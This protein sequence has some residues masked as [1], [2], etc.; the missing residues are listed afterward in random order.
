MLPAQDLFTFVYFNH[1]VGEVFF[2]LI[3]DSWLLIAACWRMALQTTIRVID[4]IL[5]STY[6]Y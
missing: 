6:T 2:P 5:K 3:T 1:S 4:N